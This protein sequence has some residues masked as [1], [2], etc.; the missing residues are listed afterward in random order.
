MA[1]SPNRCGMELI[2][3]H[4]F[5][6]VYAYRGNKQCSWSASCRYCLCRVAGTFYFFYGYCQ[7]SNTTTK[8]KM[9]IGAINSAPGA[10]RVGT[11]YVVWPVQKIFFMGIVKDPNHFC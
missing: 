5:V 8:K 2:Y 10:L 4:N 7:R 6:V 9:L 1:D 11:V 3:R